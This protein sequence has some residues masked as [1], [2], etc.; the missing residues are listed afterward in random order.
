MNKETIKEFFTLVDKAGGQNTSRMN[1]L[2]GEVV[3]ELDKL[4]LT[5]FVKKVQKCE[6][7]NQ[8]VGDTLEQLAQWGKRNLVEDVEAPPYFPPSPPPSSGGAPVD[9]VPNDSVTRHFGPIFKDTLYVTHAGGDGKFSFSTSSG[10]AYHLIYVN[11]V[12]L[13]DGAM[14]E[15]PVKK[16]DEIK[17]GITTPN[18]QDN[19]TYSINIR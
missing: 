9:P 8:V 6:A 10:N 19:C 1:Q 14:D 5:D 13:I 3:T 18:R 4:G 15:V 16:G 11:G 17:F 12:L 7:Y 2:H